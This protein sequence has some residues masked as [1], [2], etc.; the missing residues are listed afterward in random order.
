MLIFL[1]R[2]IYGTTAG[3]GHVAHLAHLLQQEEVPHLTH[4]PVLLPKLAIL[5]LLPP[6]INGPPDAAQDKEPSS[7]YVGTKKIVGRG[8]SKI[9]TGWG[10]VVTMWLHGGGQLHGTGRENL[11]FGQ[12]L[13]SFLTLRKIFNYFPDNV[14][15][16]HFFVS[17]T[18]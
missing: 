15:R 16:L 11:Q 8:G 10:G 7:S 1:C 4:L 14:K 3:R 6:K 17:G 18:G 2:A 5:L 13:A 9:V 12:N